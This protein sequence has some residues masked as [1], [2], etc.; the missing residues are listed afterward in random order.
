M[1]SSLIGLNF[2]HRLKNL[3]KIDYYELTLLQSN[4]DE[5]SRRRLLSSEDFH[6]VSLLNHLLKQEIKEELV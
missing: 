5:M 4:A 3:C 6:Q 1:R 2:N